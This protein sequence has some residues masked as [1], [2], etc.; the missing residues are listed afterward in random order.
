MS[1]ESEKAVREAWD[2]PSLSGCG[3]TEARSALDAA[4]RADERARLAAACPPTTWDAETEAYRLVEQ[5][6]REGVASDHEMM[7]QELLATR[8]ALTAVRDAVGWPDVPFVKV[9]SWVPL[10]RATRA[11]LDENKELRSRL[12]EVGELDQLRARVAELTAERDTNRSAWEAAVE[13]GRQAQDRDIAAQVRANQ[14]I[15]ERDA[16]RADVERLLV[17]RDESPLWA[18]VAAERADRVTDLRAKLAALVEAVAPVLELPI[19]PTLDATDT[20]LLRAARAAL[21]AAK[22]EP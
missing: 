11:L 5:R 10:D 16:L 12:P 7:C 21:S 19:A 15:A 8:A 1:D 6:E 22:G 3:T 4:I 20:E 9:D 14:A 2:V 17:E 18:R 13:L